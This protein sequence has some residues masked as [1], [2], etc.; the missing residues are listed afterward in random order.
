MRYR[1]IE[2][3]E[4]DGTTLEGQTEC[5]PPGS[6]YEASEG[7]VTFR[8]RITRDGRSVVAHDAAEL[9]RRL[10]SI[11]P[12]LVSFAGRFPATIAFLIALL[13]GRPRPI[14]DTPL[15]RDL[16]TGSLAE[17]FRDCL[18]VLHDSIL[19]WHHLDSSAGGPA[20]VRTEFDLATGRFVRTDA[21]VA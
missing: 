6:R 16:A 15:F 2:T 4:L 12:T 18:P 7:D 8:V 9:C 14:R 13:E 21:A 1:T 5:V 17:D 10:K 19:A 3:C 11:T 20:P